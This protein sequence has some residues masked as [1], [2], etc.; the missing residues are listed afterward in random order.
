M[1]F[2]VYL[3]LLGHKLHPHVVF[4]SLAYTIGFLT[5]RLLKKRLTDPVP[6]GIRWSII[7]AAAAGAVIGSKILY[8]LEDPAILLAHPDAQTLLGGKSIVGGLIGGLA[9]VEWVK[10]QLHFTGRTG[11]LF[12]V[13]L[14]IGIAVG[15]IGCFLTGLSDKTCG[16]A[17]S[18]PWGVDFGDGI[19]RHPAQLYEIGFLLLL[20]AALLYLMHRP[21]VQGDIFKVFMVGYGTWR[22]LI[23]FLK[24]DPAFWGLRSIQ[25]ACL[26]LL[27][28]YSRDLKR[29]LMP[30][31]PAASTANAP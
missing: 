5:F 19:R 6:Q 28:Y 25:W 1:S 9:A 30:T 7:A 24:P 17:T 13:P 31:G 16:S 11:D 29:W 4:E 20:A 26:V 23:D 15:R 10:R 18:L 12:A 2:P 27:L 3:N 21:H 8:W 22:L 14:C